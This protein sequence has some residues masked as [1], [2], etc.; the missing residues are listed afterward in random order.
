MVGCEEEGAGALSVESCFEPIPESG[1]DNSLVGRS[2]VRSSVG[3]GRRLV[4]GLRIRT[5]GKMFG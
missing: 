5:M 1:S 2:R 4:G 3:E